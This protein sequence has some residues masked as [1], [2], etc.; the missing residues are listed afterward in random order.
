M[1][2]LCLLLLASPLVQEDPSL[3]TQ[4]APLPS[5]DIVQDT[6][7]IALPRR[8]APSGLDEPLR[9]EDPNAVVRQRRFIPKPDVDLESPEF[10]SSLRISDLLTDVGHYVDGDGTLWARGRNYRAAFDADSFSMFP[11]FG[12]QAPQEFPV[13]FA[14]E[15]ATLGGEALSLNA[16]GVVRSSNAV[17]IGRGALEEVYHLDL[18]GVEQTFVFDSLPGVGALSVRMNVKSDLAAHVVDGDLYFL[19]PE[20]G[21]IAYGDAFVLDATGKREPIARSWNGTSIE[22]TVPS[23]FLASATFPVTIDPVVTAFSN[24]FGAADDASPDIVWAGRANLYWVVWEDYTSATNSDVWATSFTNGGV[25]GASFAVEGGADHWTTPKVAYHY[26]A[27]RLL[28]VASQE[29]GGLGGSGSIRGQLL[30]GAAGTLLG[31][32]FLISTTGFRKRWPD[33]GGNNWD[34]TINA[35]FCVTWS[36]DASAGNH[37]PQYRIVNWDGALVTSVQTVDSSAADSIHT[38]ISDSQGDSELFGDWW[39]MAWIDDTNDD[40]RGQ[41]MARRVVWNGNAG[42]GAG[43]FLVDGSAQSEWPSVTSRL[44]DNLVATN[45]RPS[46]VAWTTLFSSGSHP[47]GFQRSIYARV[48]TDGQAYGANLVSFTLEG[49]DGE[50]DQFDVCVATDGDAFFLTYA[51]EFHGNVGGGDWDMYMLSGHLTETST[52]A[53]LA[54]AERHENMGFSFSPE[55]RG[56]CASVFDGESSTTSDDGA[57]IWVRDTATPNGGALNGATLDVPT[58]DTSSRTAVGRQFCDANVNSASSVY[59]SENTSWVWIDGDQTL[60]LSHTVRCVDLPPNSAGYLLASTAAINVNMPGGSLGR[61]C[62]GGSGRYVNAVQSS[63]ASGTFSTMVTPMNIPQ[64]TGFVS[65][66]PGET[67]LFQYWHRDSVGGVA[68]SNFS[69]AARLMFQP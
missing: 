7:G 24:G 31:A 64:P 56:R 9:V 55:S 21:H 19:H 20:F 59:T 38:T 35:H 6:P 15:A 40:G 27:D 25:Q 69:N 48:V 4:A 49:V 46:I 58:I 52:D 61:L 22:L 65:A 29:L 18:H 2:S 66:A 37:D 28:V 16:T 13:R 60:G 8:A 1:Q 30:D 26:G 41:V 53:F 45:D 32:P 68:V 33:V 5:Q 57:A 12:R 34:S 44:D 42:S 14:L 43:N 50:L 62:L 54:L 47:S 39:T 11:I 67:W 36:F 23:A 51:E 17:T 3:L 63:G 10:Q